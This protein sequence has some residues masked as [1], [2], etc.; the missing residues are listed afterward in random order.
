MQVRAA[1]A[2]Q[3]G[4]PL[5]IEAVQLDGPK[6]GE[7]LVEIKATGIATPTSSPVSADRGP[8][9]PFSATRVPVSWWTWGPA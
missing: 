4:A 9:S 3:A 6:T 2:W 1:V 7:V 5:S 8:V